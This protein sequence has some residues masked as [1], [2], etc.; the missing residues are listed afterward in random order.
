MLLRTLVRIRDIR[1]RISTL[2]ACALILWFFSPTGFAQAPPLSPPLP[3][4]PYRIYF[5]LVS[6]P[7]ES[8]E[9]WRQIIAKRPGIF[10]HTGNNR[11]RADFPLDSSDSSSSS[12]AR[13]DDRSDDGSHN[14]S[15]NPA[16]FWQ[17]LSSAPDFTDFRQSIPVIATWGIQDYGSIRGAGFTS[18]GASKAAFLQFLNEPHDSSRYQNDGIYQ[19]YHFSNGLHIILLDLQYFQSPNTATLL[20]K[21]QWQWLEQELRRPAAVK[22][23]VSS[24]PVFTTHNNN[25]IWS[26]YPQ[27]QVRLK[28]LIDQLNL[29][30]L[31]ILHSSTSCAD[32]DC[33]DS[34]SA[35]VKTTNTQSGFPITEVCCSGVIELMRHGAETIVN[36]STN[37]YHDDHSLQK[38]L[39]FE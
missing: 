10:I 21:R 2:A 30:N 8:R 32:T 15:M 14:N 11:H 38:S 20:G 28:R 29:D 31:V 12:Y 17:Q 18:K 26:S 6:G 37:R 25:S 35:S 36:I 7:D 1:A 5:G 24:E 3:D 4:Q 27:A 13:S 33:Q 34:P 23:L 39:I 16:E 22:L 9:S 19:S